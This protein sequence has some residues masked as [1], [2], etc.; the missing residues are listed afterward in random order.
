METVNKLD[1]ARR[2]MN[3][4][5]RLFFEQ[6]DPI[7]IHTLA[8]AAAQV[9]HDLCKAHGIKT[10]FRDAKIIRADKLKYWMQ[11]LKAPE[12]FFKHADRDRNA[13]HAFRPKAA[14][15]MIFD[16]AYMYSLVTKRQT[17]EAAV[18][19]GW[20]FLNYSEMLLESDYKRDLMAI[21]SN[22]NITGS[23]IE[24]FHEMLITKHL[25]PKQ[26]LSKFD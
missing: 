23:N 11:H 4:A 21:A 6:R 3:E 8:A 16:A 9:L 1:V 10:P 2:Q 26:T 22:L 19:Q 13:T 24:T 18:F 5:I 17:Y 20:F 12:N 7:A 15:Y 14:E 25:L